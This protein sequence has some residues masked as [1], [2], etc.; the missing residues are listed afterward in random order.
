MDYFK[1]LGLLR[2]GEAKKSRQCSSQRPAE[3]RAPRR[4]GGGG[5]CFYC[6]GFFWLQMIENQ[7]RIHL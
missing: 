3:S 7:L 5:V 1:D 2:Q 6:S 4:A